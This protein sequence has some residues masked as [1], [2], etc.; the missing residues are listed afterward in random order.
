VLIGHRR[1]LGLAA[2][3]TLVVAGLVAFGGAD[4]PA[5]TGPACTRTATEGPGALV[6]GGTPRTH[7]LTLP[8]TGDGRLAP[9][10]VLLHGHRGSGAQITAT[11]G[12]PAAAAAVGYLVVAPDGVGDPARWNFDGRPDGPDDGAYLDALVAELVATACADPDRV[13]LVGSSNGAAFAGTQAC[14]AEAVVMVIATF[15]PDCPGTPPSILTVRGTADGTVT[16]EGTPA[17]VAALA[18]DA[19]CDGD[20]HVDAPHPGVERTSYHGCDGRAT[21]V[22]DTVD[23]GVHAW[24]GS[25]E[26]DRSDNSEAGRTFDATA[27]VLAFLHPVLEPS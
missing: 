7:A 22:L 14:S 4:E 2:T 5:A 16:Y 18:E 23:G 3:A 1:V 27:E 24:P 17:L 25:A 13:A 6:V 21:V 11:S 19:G 15:P 10:V 12:L 20:A 26:A 9:L 8:A